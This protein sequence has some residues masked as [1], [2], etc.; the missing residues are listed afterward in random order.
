MRGDIAAR[1]GLT[2]VLIVALV[3]TAWSGGL[4]PPAFP[5]GPTRGGLNVILPYYPPTPRAAGMGLATV[6]LPGI[7]S[8]NPAA[9]GFVEKI[10]MSCDYG[11]MDFDHGPDLDIG[12]SQFVVPTPKIGGFTKIMLFGIHT[13]HKDESRLSRVI[14]PD[15]NTYVRAREFGIASG[16]KLPLP[17][18]VPGEVA[19]GFAGFPYD[20][21]EVRLTHD[22]V[23]TAQG[24]GISKVGSIRLGLMYKPIEQASVG[25][26]YTHIKDYLRNKVLVDPQAMIYAGDSA[27]YYVNLFTVGGSVQV[28]EGMTFVVQHLF[29]RAQGPGI[30]VNYDI[31]SAGLEHSV[32][33]SEEVGVAVRCGINDGSPTFGCGVTLPHGLRV[34]YALLVNYGEQVKNDFGHGTLHIVGLGKSF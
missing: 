29:G 15:G 23:R 19:F 34:D 17:D 28:M 3:A 2:A 12:H 6:G 22:G 1:G 27:R 25:V 13:R 26:Q 18:R 20:P 4:P 16:F 33:V 8:H 21:S 31:F 9:L 32:P 5:A 14:A 7:D 24:R 11:R 10:D 30:H